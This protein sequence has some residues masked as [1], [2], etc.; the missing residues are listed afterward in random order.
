M[1][2]ESKPLAELTGVD[3]KTLLDDQVPEG[4]RLDYKRDLPGPKDGDKKE[5]LFDVSSFANASGGF[6]VYGMDEAGG[7]P[8]GLA[9]LSVANP[10][11]EIL[12]LQTVILDG[13]EPRIPGVELKFVPTST[14]KG[15]I[16]I[17][18][19]RSW[20]LPHM[21]TVQRSNKFYSRNAAG[22]YLVDVGELRTLFLASNQTGELVKR[23]RTER[24]G[25]ILA[26]E[27]PTPLDAG[28]KTILHVIPVQSFS[29]STG[30]DLKAASALPQGL[31]YP[32]GADLCNS[33]VN[34]DGLLN[35]HVLSHTSS[36]AAS[37]LQLYRSGIIE[38]VD[39]RVLGVNLNRPNGGK[40]VPSTSFEQH[41]IGHTGRYLQA[42]KL[43][44]IGPPF[45]IMLA[46]TGVKD[47]SMAAPIGVYSGSFDRDL[48]VVP[49]ILLEKSV[50]EPTDV[51][52]MLDAVWNAGGIIASPNFDSGGN[53]KPPQ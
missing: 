38:T 7:L 19:P 51:K 21:V 20:T 14:A 13:V 9:E 28:P 36:I 34:I 11:A 5:F 16:V 29:F 31:L 41:V 30:L 48:V 49:E 17:K 27:T 45:V 47:F 43:L 2:L 12:R 52:P 33:R 25:Q 15:L 53:W 39:A 26:N 3:L 23:F 40:L 6:L 37:Y 46:L 22:K 4:K 35:Y 10:D 50:C 32:F 8:T 42:L 24:I 18:I 44:G 1:I